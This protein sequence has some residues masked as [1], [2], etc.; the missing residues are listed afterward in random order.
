MKIYIAAP[1]FNPEQLALVRA[2]E[3]TLFKLSIPFYSPRSEGILDDMEMKEKQNSK[4]VIYNTNINAMDDC[5]SMIACIESRDTGTIFEVGYFAAQ[6]KDIVLYLQDVSKVSVM[7]AEAAIS[8]C[9]DV[10]WLQEAL[11]GTKSLEAK[12]WE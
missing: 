12:D 9:D 3:H 5:T 4:A 1:F 10:S 2:I 6:K 8:I 11:N 7:L